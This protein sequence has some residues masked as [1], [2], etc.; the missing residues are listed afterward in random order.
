MI[1]S[2]SYSSLADS[3][4]NKPIFNISARHRIWCSFL[5]LL[6]GFTRVFFQVRRNHFCPT[7]YFH[8]FRFESS[9]Y[10]FSENPHYQIFRPFMEFIQWFVF[11]RR[12]SYIIFLI[13]GRFLSTR[14]AVTDL[15][16]GSVFVIGSSSTAASRSYRPANL[17]PVFFRKLQPV[18]SFDS[19]PNSSF[20]SCVFHIALSRDVSPIN[21]QSH[22]TEG[23]MLL[24]GSTARRLLI[25]FAS[26]K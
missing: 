25:S 18:N 7:T 12:G 20:R 13:A 26:R 16:H 9:S 1:P 11:F 22:H 10:L 5:H 4:S 17:I 15:K 8:H 14:P 3:S 23:S 21:L 2:V 6:C 19:G 24:F